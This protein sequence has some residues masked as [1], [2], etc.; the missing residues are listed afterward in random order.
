MGGIDEAGRGSVV[1]PLVIAGI[2]FDSTGIENLR[3]QGI[4][5]SKRLTI[6]KKEALNTR[7]LQTADC[8]FICDFP[9]RFDVESLIMLY[10]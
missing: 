3:N 9:G 7:I 1:G 8:I 10:E 4:T 2:S 6:Q 5:D